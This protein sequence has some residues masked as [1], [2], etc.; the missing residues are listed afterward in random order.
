LQMGNTRA[1]ATI[2]KQVEAIIEEPESSVL[3]HM[4]RGYLALASDQYT[5]AIN[6]FQVV[7]DIEPSN[8]IASNNKA[9]CL[10]YTIDLGRA[11]G[12]L[13]E[14]IRID[15]QRNLH[16]V[17]VFNLCTLYDLKSENSQE[18]KKSIMSL[19]TRFAS[20]SFDYS[21]LKIST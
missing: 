17:I 10:L 15:P 7:L 5:T 21:C 9:I 3:V 19:I 1:A 14:L 18:K 11:I 13:E 20:D 8:L 6:H 4:N 2:L 16:E 12:T